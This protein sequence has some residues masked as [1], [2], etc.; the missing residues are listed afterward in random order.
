VRFFRRDIPNDFE[1]TV[2]TIQKS[3]H[4]LKVVYFPVIMNKK[5]KWKAIV[6]KSVLTMVVVALAALI[7]WY[8]IRAMN[9][10]IRGK[11]LNQA[12]WEASFKDRDLP[13]PL[14]GPREGYWG[15]RLGR[16][17]P[18]KLLGWRESSV[19]FPR[20]LDIDERG[21]QHVT[22]PGEDKRVVII[23]G[24]SVAFGAYASSI[25]TSYFRVIS[26]ELEEQHVT[27]TDIH[28][29]AAGAWKSIQEL[30]AL[31]LWGREYGPD[32]VI[33]LNGLN[34]VTNGATSKSLY[35]EPV[36]PK[37]GSGWTPLY[38]AHDYD[39]RVVDYLYNMRQAAEYCKGAGCRLFI[40]LQ[41]SLVERVRRSDIEEKLLKGSLKPHASAE[42]ILESYVRMRKGLRDLAG[43][44]KI[45]YFLDCSR[46]LNK[47][48]ETIFADLWHFSD[49]GH[50][51][52]GVAMARSIR[53][54]FAGF[55]P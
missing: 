11:H 43:E 35:G 21:H 41:P 19:R 23:L 10:R 28:D 15:A 24:G 40:V 31:H 27:P 22:V 26:R 52:L 44:S 17:V 39:Q 30:K 48:T 32:L 49:P 18:H 34:D 46:L 25:E 55:K 16:K 53:G 51:R 3:S 45:V 12:A 2:F 38:H 20:L 54:I 8:L 14:S 6:F 47:E 42:A 13:V 33:F 7:A 1:Y 36:A 4:L 50:Q 5:M 29:I 37:D 9:P